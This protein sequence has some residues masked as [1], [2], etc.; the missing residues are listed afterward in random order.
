M[1]NFRNRIGFIAAFQDKI[2]ADG[3]ETED[4]QMPIE[5]YDCINPACRFRFSLKPTVENVRVRCPKCG[6]DTQRLR[7]S[8]ELRIPDQSTYRGG[9]TF[10]VVLDNLRSA[11][12]AGAIFRTADAVQAERLILLGTTP[13]PLNAKVAKASLGAETA[14][15]WEHFWDSAAAID[16][17]KGDGYTL[18][19]LEGGEN[20]EN[21]FTAFGELRELEQSDKIALILGAEVS[22]V[23][24]AI[25]ARCDRIFYLPMIGTKESLNV[26]TAFGIAAYLIRYGKMTDGS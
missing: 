5:T 20:A 26:A 4:R 22:G 18:W 3:K 24:P 7:Q 25:L 6:S 9:P 10:T 19:A 13:T 1:I 2:K 17:L 16:A 23:D 21:L 15:K 11:L 8:D 12:N 14:V